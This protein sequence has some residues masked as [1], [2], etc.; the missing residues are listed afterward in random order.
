[1]SLFAHS[2]NSRYQRKVGFQGEMQVDGRREVE[3]RPDYG[4]Q[5]PNGF[6][7]DRDSAREER[8]NRWGNQ[9]KGQEVPYQYSKDRAPPTQHRQEAPQPQFTSSPLVPTSKHTALPAASAPFLPKADWPTSAAQE[10]AMRLRKQEELKRLLDEQL[11]HRRQQA[12][13]ERQRRIIAEQMEDEKLKKQRKELEDEYRRELRSR[14]G[15]SPTTPEP[16]AA[17]KPQRVPKAPV[18]QSIS[19]Q[20]PASQSMSP[21]KVPTH[22]TNRPS[23]P[24]ASL[25]KEHTQRLQDSFQARDQGIQALL[26]RLKEESLSLS[27]QRQSALQELDSMRKDLYIS[28]NVPVEPWR[29]FPEPRREPD[30]LALRHESR[31][32][33]I[34]QAGMTVTG[35]DRSHVV[36]PRDVKTYGEVESPEVS[37]LLS[38]LDGILDYW[39]GNAPTNDSLLEPLQASSFT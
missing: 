12:A 10:R 20:V 4:S 7:N 27:A 17:P 25:P 33:P 23:L 9:Q 38:Q 22:P 21:Q 14:Q 13:E 18:S 16:K 36:L 31:F 3:R 1:M 6:E 19:P 34:M 26:T 39:K 2:S 24:F 8:E 29:P 28:R 32:M 30:R 11:E 37:R 15:L 35:V 5:W